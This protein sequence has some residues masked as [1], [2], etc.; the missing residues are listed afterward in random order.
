MYIDTYI[1]AI[2]VHNDQRIEFNFCVKRSDDEPIMG[3][4]P[5]HPAG[6]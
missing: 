3:M 4:R 5:M 2:I 1:H 6:I